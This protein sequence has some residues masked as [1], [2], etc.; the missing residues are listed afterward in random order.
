[1]YRRLKWQRVGSQHMN[2]V[3]QSLLAP[4]HFFKMAGLS[5]SPSG[6][7]LNSG[8]WWSN[9][10]NSHGCESSSSDRSRTAPEH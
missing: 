2:A 4:G 1:M 8:L 9:E 3:Y 6:W 10:E 7:V 5:N